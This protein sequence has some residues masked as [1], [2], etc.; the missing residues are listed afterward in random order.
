M[1]I[2]LKL[3]LYIIRLFLSNVLT[4]LLTFMV[5]ILLI[6]ALEILRKASDKNIPT[7]IILQMVLLKFPLMGQKIM[8]FVMLIGAVLTYRKLSNA[9]E[10]VV[11]RGAGISVWEFLA[12][13]LTCSFA[14]GILV[15]TVINP[16]SAVMIS[17]YERLEGKYFHGKDSYLS[18]SSSGL[19]LRQ[20][21]A[22]YTNKDDRGE[23]IIYAQNIDKTSESAGEIKLYDVTFFVYAR[24]D[25]FF[26][27]IDAKEATLLQ[28]YWHLKNVIITSPESISTKVEEYFLETDL[29][30]NDIH[31][32]F[33]SP[34]TISFWTLP[35]FIS[36]L[37]KSG[38]SALPHRLHWHSI[39]TNPF[40]YAAM[41]LI[42][43]LF[44][45]TPPRQG[46]VGLLITAGIVTGFFIYFMSNLVLSLGL[47]GNMP[48][49]LAAWAPTGVSMLIGVL[50]LLHFEDG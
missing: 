27:R 5:I 31:N 34:D 30:V 15:T 37:T 17:R 39:L 2:S 10:L 47:S 25:K 29:T 9:S 46:R 22:L 45:L 1:R 4:A 24:K 21:N 41:I 12:P 6:D 44:S 23:V 40:Y 18:L 20:S 28:N 26:R 38:F 33:A 16:L 48:V 36:T 50:L 19:W 11:I 42:A 13:T 3:S 14:I 32:S 35:G 8:P 7:L 49:M 43:A